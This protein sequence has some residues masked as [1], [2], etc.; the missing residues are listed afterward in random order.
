MRNM[1]QQLGC[2]FCI[3]CAQPICRNQLYGMRNK[4]M[5]ANEIATLIGLV[6]S[7]AIIAAIFWMKMK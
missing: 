5:S 2:A 3:V 1:G 6:A 7:V 4:A